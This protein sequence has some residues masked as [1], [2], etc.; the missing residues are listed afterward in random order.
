MKKQVAVLS[1]TERGFELAKKIRDAFMDKQNLTANEEQE[2]CVILYRKGS[3]SGKSDA[4][5]VSEVR[6]AFNFLDACDASGVR[7]EDG[8]CDASGVR[9]EDGVCDASGV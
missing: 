6:E 4:P 8:V 2:P 3:M 7:S 5:A 1:F 9:S